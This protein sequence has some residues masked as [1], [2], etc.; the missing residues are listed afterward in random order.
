L[1]TLGKTFDETFQSLYQWIMNTQKEI[2]KSLNLILML[3]WSSKGKFMP[4]ARCFII[5]S[6]EHF[7]PFEVFPS[8]FS[9]FKNYYYYSFIHMC[10]HCLGHFSPS[11]HTPP[12]PTQDPC[13]SAPAEPVLPLS[14]ILLKRSHKH[15]K[16]DK[17]FLL[18]EL[19]I[20]IQKDS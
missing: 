8:Y 19:R 9:F 16:E 1:E 20:A 5:R 4:A 7:T 6:S 14:L 17:T 2:K 18:V 12:P 15:N 3:L 10:I 13:P 11:P